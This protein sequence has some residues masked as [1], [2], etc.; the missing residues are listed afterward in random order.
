MEH[1]D[2]SELEKL[3][4]QSESSIA[5][6]KVKTGVLAVTVGGSVGWGFTTVHENFS[7]IYADAALT[8][9]LATVAM[10]GI[11]LARQ[12]IRKRNP[13]LRHEL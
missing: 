10:I 9:N 3:Y 11:P 1:G 4:E 8:T 5:W 12:M 7:K 13:E 2:S 6:L